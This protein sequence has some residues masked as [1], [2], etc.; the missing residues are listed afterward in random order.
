VVHPRAPLCSELN[1]R[2][3]AW[4]PPS[5]TVTA[6][7][8]GRGVPYV[9]RNIPA[10]MVLP[11]LPLPQSAEQPAFAD[12]VGSLAIRRCRPGQ[13]ANRAE[14]A[15]T[16][17]RFTAID[18]EWVY[19]L[20]G[21]DQ[22]SETWRIS[23]ARPF[24]RTKG[25]TVVD[26]SSATLCPAAG[27]GWIA[28][29]DTSIAFDPICSQGL[30]HA[31]GSAIVAAGAILRNDGISDEAAAA[32]DAASGATAERTESLRKAVYNTMRS[33]VNEEIVPTA[34]PR[35][36]PLDRLRSLLSAR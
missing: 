2:Y 20:T 5:A 15:D 7:A 25:A 13:A 32:Y 18:D 36:L 22:R 29:G 33:K 19:S 10:R 30:A 8:V 1:T 24:V 4:A 3:P 28:V 35:F 27:R 17:L 14:P 26:A 6:G 21:P 34:S 16:W 9:H 23:S 12:P 11:P 31:V